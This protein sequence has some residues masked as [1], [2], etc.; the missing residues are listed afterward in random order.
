MSLMHEAEGEVYDVLDALA[1][2][3][4]ALFRAVILSPSSIVLGPRRS[5]GVV[6]E[7]QR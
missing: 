2:L 1:R 4:G 6:I 3:Y 5:G 7:G